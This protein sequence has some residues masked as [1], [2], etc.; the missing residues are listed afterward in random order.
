MLCTKR[1]PWPPVCSLIFALFGLSSQWVKPIGTRRKLHKYSVTLGR[2]LNL[3]PQT[4]G[5]IA[6]VMRLRGGGWGEGTGGGAGGGQGRAGKRPWGGGDGAGDGNSGGGSGGNGNWGGQRIWGGEWASRGA[7]DNTS[8][9]KQSAASG[10]D[11]APQGERPRRAVTARQHLPS[12]PHLPS[13]QHL[14]SAPHLPRAL[15]ELAAA[16]PL[17]LDSGGGLALVDCQHGSCVVAWDGEACIETSLVKCDRRRC[18]ELEC[19]RSAKSWFSLHH[20]DQL[21]LREAA[22]Q[23]LGEVKNSWWGRQAVGGNVSGESQSGWVGVAETFMRD[24]RWEHYI[25]AVRRGGDPSLTWSQF[26]ERGRPHRKN[27]SKGSHTH[28]R[29]RRVTP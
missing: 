6:S 25:V 18:V 24:P 12:A 14:P 1:V 20:V 27:R 26:L 2:I 23:Q 11:D 7:H 29:R 3:P 21:M 10:G 28:V 9:G 22:G 4:S 13:A 15:D 17:P 5:G 8:S 19:M 16:K